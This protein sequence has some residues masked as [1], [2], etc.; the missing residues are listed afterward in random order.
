MREIIYTSSKE[1]GEG[2][3]V[4]DLDDEL[5]VPDIDIIDM[6]L[7]GSSAEVIGTLDDVDEAADALSQLKR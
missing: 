4:E 2:P 3:I 7:R 5:F 1:S 6:K